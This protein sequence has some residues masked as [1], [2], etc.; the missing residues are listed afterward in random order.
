MDAFVGNPPFAGGS[1]VSGT[2]G[3]SYRAWLLMVHPGSH[4]NDDLCAHFFRRADY[5]LGQPGTV[6]LIATNTISQGD[7]RSTGLQNMVNVGSAIY[8]AVRT[9]KWPGEANVA[10][11]VVHLAKGHLANIS[12]LRRRLDGIEVAAINSRLRP[13]PE[14]SN[15]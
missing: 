12:G 5:L 13:K 3:D 1:K 2:F 8:D 15:P 4:G 11:S 7:T 14:R 9:M 10:V 6:G